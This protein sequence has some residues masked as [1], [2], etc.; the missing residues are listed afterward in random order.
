VLVS[1]LNPSLI[2]LDAG[3]LTAGDPFMAAFTKAVVE[4]S[5]P[6]AITKLEFAI[7]T[8]GHSAGLV[9]AAYMVVDELLSPQHLKLGS[10]HGTPA[11]RADLIHQ[12]S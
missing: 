12:N 10:G 9:G 6:S 2:L 8:L 5:L 3:L 7:S 4:R 11:G 1:A